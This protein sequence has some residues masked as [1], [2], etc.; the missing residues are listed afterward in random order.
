MEQKVEPERLNKQFRVE[1]EDIMS[2]KGKSVSAGPGSQALGGARAGSSQ[3]VNAYTR[4]GSSR[5]RSLPVSL[6]LTWDLWGSG[7]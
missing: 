1:M 6:L 4:S 3:R 2:S 5:P 7:P